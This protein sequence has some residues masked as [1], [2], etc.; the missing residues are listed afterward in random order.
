M[1]LYSKQ[2]TGN[3]EGEKVMGQVMM[4][5]DGDSKAVIDAVKA[6]VEKISKTLRRE[7]CLST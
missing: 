2:F 5:K 3:G 1:R 7:D 6:R 4:L